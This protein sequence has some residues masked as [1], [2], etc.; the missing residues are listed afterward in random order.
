MKF[1]SG[2]L[3]TIGVT[4][5]GAVGFVGGE[6]SLGSKGGKA[7]ENLGGSNVGACLFTSF[8]LIPA[9]ISTSFGGS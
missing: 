6:I 4:S 7:P 1:I 9:L 3:N 8:G 2:G 5:A